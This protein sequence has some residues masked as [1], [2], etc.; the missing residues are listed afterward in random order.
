VPKRDSAQEALRQVEN[1]TDSKPVKGE[2]LLRSGK[3]KKAITRGQ[4]Q[5]KKAQ[6]IRP[7]NLISARRENGAGILES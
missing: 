5:G 1:L 2:T 6:E 3:L 4:I 7:P